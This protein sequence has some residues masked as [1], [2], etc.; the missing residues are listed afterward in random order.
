MDNANYFGC[1]IKSGLTVMQAEKAYREANNAENHKAVYEWTMVESYMA[2]AREEYADSSFEKAEELA[3]KA[4]EWMDEASKAEKES[5]D[6]G[7]W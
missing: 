4:M 6:K 7:E 5:S 3:I 2:K 1:A